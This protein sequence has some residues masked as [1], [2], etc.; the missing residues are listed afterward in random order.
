VSDGPGRG[1]G[2]AVVFARYAF[3]P[4]ALGYCGPGSVDTLFEHAHTGVDD[5]GVR[6]LAREFEGAWPYLEVLAGAVGVDDPLDRRVVE[7][8]WLGSPA[9]SRVTLHDLGT[10][11]EERFRARAGTTWERLSRALRPGTPLCHAFHVLCVSPW[12]G[13]LRAGVAEAP[14]EVVD[15]CRIRWGTVTGVDG[16][17][18]RVESQRLEWDGGALHLGPARHEWLRHA[19]DGA[20]LGRPPAPGDT[21][22]CHWDWVCDVLSPRRVTWLRSSTQAMLGLANGQRGAA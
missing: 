12:V 3:P 20:S 16:D 21:V 22:S 2:G 17:R 19:R 7:A 1:L 18:C 14:L 15:R 4:N 11:V 9:A 13:L 10:S 5:G 8:Y 6:P